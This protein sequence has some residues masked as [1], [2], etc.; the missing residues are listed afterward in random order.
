MFG[1]EDT[2]L[3]Q[4]KE[5]EEKKEEEQDPNFDPLVRAKKPI[6]VKYRLRVHIGLGFRF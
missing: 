1:N 5:E 6:L 3:S 4:E 2:N